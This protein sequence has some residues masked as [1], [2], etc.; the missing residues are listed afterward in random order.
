[1]A[2]QGRA[3]PGI[4]ALCRAFPPM[5]PLKG[6]LKEGQR[7]HETCQPAQDDA[8]LAGKAVW[9]AA[10]SGLGAQWRTRRAAMKTRNK[11]ARYRLTAYRPSFAA[12][13]AAPLPSPFPPFVPPSYTFCT[14]STSRLMVRPHNGR[15]LP[16][17]PFGERS[18]QRERK[19]T[20]HI[21]LS[22]AP[23]ECSAS[24]NPFV[25]ARYDTAP[26]CVH[27]SVLVAR[28]QH[29]LAVQG[30]WPALFCARKKKTRKGGGSVM[31]AAGMLWRWH[32]QNEW[33]TKK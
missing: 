3:V 33:A 8:A 13:R 9:V 10:S 22:E 20:A 21:I 27:L 24:P 31:A 14:Q 25:V 4:T 6:L 17:R 32:E 12:R 2:L 7:D 5:K 30:T 11:P 19:K 18:L 15:W 1:M 16:A 26:S 29:H 23:L 28:R